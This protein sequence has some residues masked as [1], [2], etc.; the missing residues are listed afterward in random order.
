MFS[1]K[2]KWNSTRSPQND[3]KRNRN[4][5]RVKT[6]DDH[7]TVGEQHTH[8][9]LTAT[10]DLYKPQ[11]QL[12]PQL[13]WSQLHTALQLTRA[14]AAASHAQTSPNCRAPHK[15][16]AHDTTT[17]TVMAAKGGSVC[18]T[19]A[20]AASCS[21]LQCPQGNKRSIATVLQ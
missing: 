9:S 11:K 10:Q 6:Q 8:A 5:T 12:W 21:W 2:A 7:W 19:Q 20:S 4:G 14:T 17:I 15:L 3:A 1:N 16:Q 18:S 13:L